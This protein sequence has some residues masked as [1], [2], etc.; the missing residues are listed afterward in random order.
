MLFPALAFTASAAWAEPPSLRL[1][2]SSATL[3]ATSADIAG[4]QNIDNGPTGATLH[5]RLAS[6]LDARMLELTSAHLDEVAELW[7]CDELVV[8][9]VIRAPMPIASFVVTDPDPARIA[10]LEAL[11]ASPDCAN[12]AQD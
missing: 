3:D 9:P 7:I 12:P 10:R 11:L 6:H 2:F 1:V 8:A 4:A 5:I